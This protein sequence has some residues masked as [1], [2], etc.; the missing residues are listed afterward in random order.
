M[1]AGREPARDAMTPRSSGREVSA[2]AVIPAVLREPLAAPSATARARVSLWMMV[3]GN[4][5][6]V[7]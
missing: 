3:T 6:P 2:R 7:A 5:L 1:W 4:G